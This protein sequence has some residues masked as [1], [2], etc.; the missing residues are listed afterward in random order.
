MNKNTATTSN[1][2][3]NVRNMI[4][5][6]SEN[7][8]IVNAVEILRKDQGIDVSD[9]LGIYADDNTIDISNENTLY[10]LIIYENS[11][12]LFKNEEFVKEYKY[13]S[14]YTEDEA[15][16]QSWT[17]TPRHEKDKTYVQFEVYDL[18]DTEAFVNNMPWREGVIY[19]QDMSLGKFGGCI[20]FPACDKVVEITPLFNQVI[21]ALNIG[22]ASYQFCEI[23]I[24]KNDEVTKIKVED[25]L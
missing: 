25:L 14:I 12:L 23:H 3:A 7:V 19:V 21:D 1:T 8:K 13:N 10:R 11:V 6:E 5:A 17:K 2:T 15:N 9:Y 18:K 4:F 22:G 16:R 24:H 20:H